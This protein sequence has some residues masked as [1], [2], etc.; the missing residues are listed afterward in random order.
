MF[1][2]EVMLVPL[3]KL[4]HRTEPRDQ[5]SASWQ[6]LE[7]EA[8]Q[9]EVHLSRLLDALDDALRNS[10]FVCGAFSAADISLFM[11]VFWC[12]RLAGPSLGDRRA[13]L[14]WFRLLQTR[15]SFNAMT[16]EVYEQDLRLSA[17]VLDSYPD[18]PQMRDSTALP[19]DLTG[20]RE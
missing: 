15:P 12:Q 18:M 17:R 14:S 8:K 5:T 6:K 11:Q 7:T 16:A 3:R 1:A 10:R 2:D 20:P 19:R 4:L 9:A 13:L